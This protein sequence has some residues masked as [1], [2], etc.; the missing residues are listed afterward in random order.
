MYSVSFSKA[1][2]VAGLDKGLLD[3]AV[4]DNLITPST[5]LLPRLINKEIL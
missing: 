4:S 2:E 3:L 5:T 1:P